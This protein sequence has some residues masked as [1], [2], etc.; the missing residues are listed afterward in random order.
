[1]SGA[2]T[3]TVTVTISGTIVNSS[4]SVANPLVISDIALTLSLN[5][6]GTDTTTTANISGT[7]ENDGVK[8]TISRGRSR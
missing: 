8:L 2:G 1:M 4:E 7:V 6:L 3:G 5:S